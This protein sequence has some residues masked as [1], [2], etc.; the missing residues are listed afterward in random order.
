[1]SCQSA[2]FE[3]P[4][5]FESF[6]QCDVVEVV[7]AVDG[8]AKGLVILL[9][10]EQAV[11]CFV[12]GLEVEFLDGDKVGFDERNIVSP[13]KHAGCASV[14]NARDEDR[15]EIVEEHGLFLV[16]ERESLAIGFDVRDPY[17]DLLELIVLPSVS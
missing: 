16:I 6:R 8:V 12:D 13:L 1:M 2:E 10:N 9:F 4:V 14:I 5:A 15:E 3:E 17:N 11:A 7:E